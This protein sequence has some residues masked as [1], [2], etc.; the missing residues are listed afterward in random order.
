MLMMFTLGPLTEIK[1]L[2]MHGFRSVAGCIALSHSMQGVRAGLSKCSDQVPDHKHAFQKEAMEMPDTVLKKKWQ[3][4]QNESESGVGLSGWR[5]L[6]ERMGIKSNC[7]QGLC[8]S[9]V[10]EP[11]RGQL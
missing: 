8:T 9:G 3:I 10:V 5:A 6:T 4:G 1:C 2:P 7:G 11:G